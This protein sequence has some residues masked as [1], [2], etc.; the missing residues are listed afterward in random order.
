MFTI[1]ND[2]NN[3]ITKCNIFEKDVKNK[4]K[5]LLINNNVEKIE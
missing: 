2:N 1:L 3:N 5:N 4:I